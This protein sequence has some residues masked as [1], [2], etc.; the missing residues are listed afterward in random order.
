MALY[1]YYFELVPLRSKLKVNELMTQLKIQD[2]FRRAISVAIN[3]LHHISVK[4][5]ISGYAIAII[6]TNFDCD[7]SNSVSVQSK[8]RVYTKKKTSLEHLRSVLQDVRFF[9]DIYSISEINEVPV[10]TNSYSAYIRVRIP[11]KKKQLKSYEV[12]RSLL[13]SLPDCNY[14]YLMPSSSIHGSKRLIRY[15]YKVTSMDFLKI[16]QYS[17]PDGYGFSRTTRLCAVANI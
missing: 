13:E 11:T 12:K 9:K 16:A 8:I 3:T 15:Y 6:E 4:K 14:I 5:S 17:K 2:A 7:P 10:S 1:G